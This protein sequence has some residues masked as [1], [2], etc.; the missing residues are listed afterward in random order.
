MSSQQPSQVH[1]V[2]GE[3]TGAEDPHRD[4]ERLEVGDPVADQGGV[5]VLEGHAVDHQVDRDD[6][7]GQLAQPGRRQPAHEVLGEHG[8]A[9]LGLVVPGQPAGEHVQRLVGTV[10]VGHHVGP[11]LVVEQRLDPADGHAAGGAIR[12]SPFDTI[13][14]VLPSRTSTWDS[15]SGAK[16]R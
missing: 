14:P 7:R 4:R 13:T 9:L 6:P 12:T 16:A 2:L 1:G 15:R 10:D 3:P 5:H 11:D 8:E